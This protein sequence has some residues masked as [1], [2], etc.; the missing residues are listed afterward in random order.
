MDKEDPK[1]R[2]GKYGSKKDQ[3]EKARDNVLGSQKHIRRIIAIQEKQK[4]INL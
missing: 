2:K 4:I 3:K 1:S